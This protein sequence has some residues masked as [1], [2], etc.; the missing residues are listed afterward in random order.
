MKVDYGLLRSV[1]IIRNKIFRW[2][3]DRLDTS[4]GFRFPFPLV[5]EKLVISS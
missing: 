2:V 5:D 4:W 3:S 1:T